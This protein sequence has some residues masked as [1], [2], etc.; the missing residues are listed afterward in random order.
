MNNNNNSN[1]QGSRINQNT[2]PNNPNGTYGRADL[3]NIGNQ[4]TSSNDTVPFQNEN[5]AN[6]SLVPSSRRNGQGM[7]RP[8]GNLM[9]QETV[10]KA[11]E[12]LD[13]MGPKGKVASKA[14][15]TANKA[16]D[17]LKGRNE[18]PKALQNKDH[19]PAIPTRR[20]TSETDEDEKENSE[21]KEEQDQ[22]E[23]SEN[24]SE[25]KKN[26]REK[27]T[28]KVPLKVK[29]QVISAIAIAFITCF[30]LFYRKN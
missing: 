20:N 18:T 29:K 4:S 7:K 3:R 28:L 19:M 24:D 6:A 17:K 10:N 14:L 5:T 13:K 2:T 11:S 15:Q 1:N 12:V 8:T 22:N 23:E 9:R 16:Y 21:E 26:V 25:E 30:D 27:G